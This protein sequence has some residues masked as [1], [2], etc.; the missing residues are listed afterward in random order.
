MD[1]RPSNTPFITN[2]A[3]SDLTTVETNPDVTPKPLTANRYE[4]LLEMQK[5][6]P[7]SKCISK[8]L[9]NGKAPQHEADLFT[10][11]RIIIQTHHGCRSE[12]LALI[13]PKAWKYAI[14]VKAHDKL[15]HQGVTCTYCLIKCQYYWKGMNKDIWNT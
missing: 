1:T 15:G 3:T 7:S 14:L 6:D 11:V 12:I 4:A 9:S 13:I 2:A 8:Q 5:T 10:Y